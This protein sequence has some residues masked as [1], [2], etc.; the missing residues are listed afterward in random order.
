MCWQEDA[1]AANTE[2]QAL[3]A[4]GAGGQ[5]DAEKML[6]G[7]VSQDRQEQQGRNA[8]PAETGGR[9]SR[10]SNGAGGMSQKDA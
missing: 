5:R 1:Q 7:K 2:S 4:G 3:G 10:G 6:P 8:A 9:F